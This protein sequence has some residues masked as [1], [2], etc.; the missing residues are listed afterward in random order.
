MKWLY[1]GLIS[2]L[3]L[4][5]VPTLDLEKIMLD[6][7]IRLSSPDLL[8]H[9]V[10]HHWSCTGCL[11]ACK[12]ISG[13]VRARHP[14]W[15]DAK[16]YSSSLEK[17]RSEPAPAGVLQFLGFE[18]PWIEQH[19]HENS[20]VFD[21]KD[22][23]LFS[24]AARRESHVVLL[25]DSFE[26]YEPGCMRNYLECYLRA[27]VRTLESIPE[28]VSCKLWKWIQGEAFM[29]RRPSLVILELWEAHIQKDQMSDIS[30]VLEQ[31]KIQ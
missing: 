13:H 27:P 19:H 16:P 22:Q 7:K 4:R 6:E 21:V 2:E 5:G 3:E 12:A 31:F 28:P 17:P 15:C 18:S 20:W 23:A 8:Y 11:V 14:E 24:E 25:G 26:D 29:Q 9:S 10:D 1:R 30:N